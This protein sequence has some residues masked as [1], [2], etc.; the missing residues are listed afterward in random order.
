MSWSFRDNSGNRYD[1]FTGDEY[2]IEG[3]GGTIGVIALIVFLLSLIFGGV[4]DVFKYC[5]NIMIWAPIV[6]CV[7]S[8][9][10][11]AIILKCELHPAILPIII[12]VLG[13]VI[14]TTLIINT[15]ENNMSPNFFSILAAIIIAFF[16][17]FLAVLAGV[18]LALLIG[19][20]ISGILILTD[21]SDNQDDKD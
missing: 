4:Y 5:E 13:T 16:E 21:K 12:G 18:L 6:V 1:V 2:I 20:A 15:L 8:A 3:V 11:F 17:N 10:S 19:L 14:E 7:L 9:S